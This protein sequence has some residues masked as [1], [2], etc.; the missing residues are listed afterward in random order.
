MK[1]LI[2]KNIPYVA[3]FFQDHLNDIEYFI[4]QDF[5]IPKYPEKY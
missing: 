2:D 5:D 1:I 3:H 4:D